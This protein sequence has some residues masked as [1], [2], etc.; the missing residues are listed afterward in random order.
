M[1]ESDIESIFRVAVRRAGGIPIKVIA[2]TAGIPDRCVVWGDGRVQ[3]VELKTTTG[4][5][6]PIQRVMHAR[7]AEHHAP[8]AVLYGAAEVR[9]W[10]ARRGLPSA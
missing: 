4:A 1:H 8:V 9:D 3:F 10:A 6:E 2:T 5:L 7:F